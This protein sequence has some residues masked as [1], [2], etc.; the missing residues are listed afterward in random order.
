MQRKYYGRGLYIFLWKKHKRAVALRV[1]RSLPD[2]AGGFD[3]FPYAEEAYDP[4]GQEAQRQV[5]LEPADLVD[6]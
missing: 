3:S 1:S 2:L 5:P 6:P 4:N